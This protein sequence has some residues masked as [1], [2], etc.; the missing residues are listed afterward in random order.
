MVCLHSPRRKNVEP[1]RSFSPVGVP[2]VRTLCVS[3][4]IMVQRKAALV[5]RGGLKLALSRLGHAAKG[6]DEDEL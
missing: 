4:T 3:H 6:F 2:A 5:R 1:K